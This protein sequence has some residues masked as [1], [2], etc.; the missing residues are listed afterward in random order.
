M[1]IKNIQKSLLIFFVVILSGCVSQ[2]PLPQPIATYE[3]VTT[4]TVLPS[5]SPMPTAVPLPVTRLTIGIEG[6]SIEPNVL[7]YLLNNHP[8]LSDSLFQSVVH[9]G[10]FKPNPGSEN[11][12]PVIASSPAVEWTKTNEGVEGV[13]EIKP[14]IRW[15]DGSFLT[16]DDILY[17]FNLMKKLASLY[18][19]SNREILLSSSIEED[20]NGIRISYKN[21]HPQ[22]SI[23]QS[24]FT[25]PILQKNY[26]EL[27]TNQ[28]FE[29]QYAEQ[30]KIIAA[31][32]DS[33]TVD[34]IQ[35]EQE[36]NIQLQQLNDTLIQINNKKSKVGELK[37][38]LT[39]RHAPHNKNG[40]KDGEDLVRS[41]SNI[42]IILGEISILQGNLDKQVSQFEGIRSQVATSILHQQD[43]E[44]KMAGL[45]DEIS[46]HLSEEDLK[47]EPLVIPFHI[48]V[49]SPN[50][51]EIQAVSDQVSSPNYISIQ[52]MP[53]EDLIN[54]YQQG[55]LDTIF[56][57][58]DKEFPAEKKPDGVVKISSIILNP[59]S[60]KL[61]NPVLSQAIAC[62]FTSPYL[63]EGSSLVGSD[64]IQAYEAAPGPTLDLPGCS[65]PYNTRLLNMRMMLDKN[66]FTWNYLRNGTIVSGS[67]KDPLGQVIS[68]LTLAVDPNYQ[69]P[70]DVQEKFTLSLKKLGIDISISLLSK[71]FR[72]ST[73]HSVD[74]ILSNWQ[75]NLSVGDQ[76]CSL[77][78]FPGYSHLPIHMKF[79]LYKSC[80]IPDS[81]EPS[82][83]Q[84]TPSP[85]VLLSGKESSSS[86][87]TQTYV[88]L[89]KR[90]ELFTHVNT[91]SIS[92]Y[93]LTWL[94]PLAPSWITSW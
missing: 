47:E 78:A 7:N 85:I 12:I 19:G 58:T 73:D 90:D 3:P 39:N 91:E 44:E 5:P 84:P 52:A 37:I 65:G 25:F 43:L 32:I 1:A 93:S 9:P 63:W 38:F 34:R 61:A 29:D 30:I 18:L 56:S 72:P 57:Y 53:S 69:L 62:I 27:Y 64:S 17:S 55:K 33:I 75:T 35:L 76:L 41:S 89:L 13:V 87:L 28:F 70:A 74:L 86:Y 88:V 4:A 67:M 48:N 14:D 92:K 79:A 6:I 68:P 42:I 23:I 11:L 71:S 26:W 80:G 40:V 45:V 59:F 82:V 15:S 81:I 31:E 8:E 24:L 36:L 51:V 22:P 2:T 77:P 60:D 54:N 20:P 10:L 16:S 94:F 21:D 50:F 83:T 66:L 49:S 46:N